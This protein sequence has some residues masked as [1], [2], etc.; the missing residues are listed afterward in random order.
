MLIVAKRLCKLIIDFTP[1]IKQVY[2]TST[3]LHAAL[4]AANAACSTL[5]DEL[6]DVREYGD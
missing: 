1:V 5:H 6:T 3:A 4:A 2:P